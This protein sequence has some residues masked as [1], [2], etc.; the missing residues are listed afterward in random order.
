MSEQ[1]SADDWSEICALADELLD[2]GEA[3]SGYSARGRA[4]ALRAELQQL[5]AEWDAN[6]VLHHGA[7]VV[8]EGVTWEY[9]PWPGY[10][11]MWKVKS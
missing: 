8:Q 4:I 2:A 1:S 6:A 3:C 10:E 7:T 11:E 9:V 5:A